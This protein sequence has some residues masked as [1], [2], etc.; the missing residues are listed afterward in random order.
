VSETVQ[1][2]TAIPALVPDATRSDEELKPESIDRVDTGKKLSADYTGKETSKNNPKGQVTQPH[3]DFTMTPGHH[4]IIVGVFSILDNSMKFTKEMMSKGYVVNVALNPQ[5]N[6]YYV[7]L[8]SSIV[9]EEAQRIR[10]E[11]KSKNVFK[12][13]WVFSME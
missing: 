12:Q 4:Y 13:A 3:E 2:G 10:D 1:P 8:S 9:K 7:Y 6:L 11:Y 5:N